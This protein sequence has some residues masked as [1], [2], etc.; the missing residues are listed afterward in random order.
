MGEE[1]KRIVVVGGGAAGLVAAIAAARN[2]ATVT[3]LERM[4]RVGKKILATG[5]GRCNLTNVNQSIDKYHG[6][7]PE[8]I[9]GILGRFGLDRTLSFFSQLGIE[10]VFEEHGYVYPASGQASSVL[11][12]LRYE[13]A[14]LEVTILCGTKISSIERTGVGLRCATPDNDLYPA[15]CVILTAG[16]KSAPN[17]GSNGSGFKVAEALGHTVKEPFPALV[18]IRLDAPFLKRLSGLRI[19][20]QAEIRMDDDI[21]GGERGEML[22]TD[23]GISGIPA[24]QLSRCVSEYTRTNRDLHFHLDLFPDMLLR[25]LTALIAKRTSYSPHKT[26]EMSFVGLLHKRLIPVILQEA[27]YTS[28]KSPCGDLTNRDIERIA[29]VMKDW[30]MKCVGVKSWMFSQ[31]TAGGISLDEIN[32]RTLE[33]KIV[34]GLFFAGEILDVDGDCGGYNLQWAW[35]SGYIAGE[36][37]A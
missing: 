20:G 25:E 9:S 16:G 18:Q 19:Q 14:R 27:G 31:V 5:N 28:M 2:G 17:L 21:Q 37:A 32:A 36:S 24:M 33:S 15:D 23:Y 30:P 11:D 6:G 13:L 35:S 3:V 8:V 4:D 26:L 12:V 1:T 7:N 22:F 34:P 29:A 10:P